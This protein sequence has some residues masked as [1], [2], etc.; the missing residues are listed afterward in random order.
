MNS[1]ACVLGVLQN[2]ST[3]KA[4]V[5]KQLGRYIPSNADG[6]PLE[7]RLDPPHMERC[8]H[9]LSRVVSQTSTFQIFVPTQ[10]L[11]LPGNWDCCWSARKFGKIQQFWHECRML[12]DLKKIFIFWKNENNLY[13]LWKRSGWWILVSSVPFILSCGSADVGTQHFLSFATANAFFTVLSCPLSSSLPVA[14][15]K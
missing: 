11:Q 2:V 12:L 6:C 3:L 5:V 13:Y 10:Y 1:C 9:L 4:V 8:E 15:A 7:L 14:S